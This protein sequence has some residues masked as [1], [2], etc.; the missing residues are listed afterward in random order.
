MI[1]AVCAILS[2]LLFCRLIHSM[3]E[4]IL[5][6]SKIYQKGLEGDVTSP[7]I[8]YAQKRERNM[9]AVLS[10]SCSIKNKNTQIEKGKEYLS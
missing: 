5:I 8:V 4:M 3:L 2:I 1:P 7:F 9:T 10:A 6:F